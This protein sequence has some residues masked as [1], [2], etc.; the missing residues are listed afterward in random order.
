VSRAVTAHAQLAA[1]E[2]DNGISM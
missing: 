1:D 2:Q